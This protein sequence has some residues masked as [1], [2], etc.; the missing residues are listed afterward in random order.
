MKELFAFKIR[1]LVTVQVVA[2]VGHFVALGVTYR[3]EQLN[4]VTASQIVTA[5]PCG[6]KHLTK[7][8][9]EDTAKTICAF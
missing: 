9:S 1:S 4:Y 5:A 3:N 8:F 6:T 7:V 2:N